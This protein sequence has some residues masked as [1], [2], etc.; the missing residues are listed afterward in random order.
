MANCTIKVLLLCPI[1]L[2]MPHFLYDDRL[3][4]IKEKNETKM[5]A[6]QLLHLTH[7]YSDTKD[8]SST[9]GSQK[10]KHVRNVIS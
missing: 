3:P 6:M 10:S 8:V 5:Q 1:S 4:A 9:N 2:M 7:N